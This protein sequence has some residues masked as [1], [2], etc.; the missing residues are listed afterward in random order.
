MREK[1]ATPS[2]ATN[3]EGSQTM[4]DKRQNINDNETTDKQSSV[5]MS[6]MLL[7]Q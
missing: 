5:R 7:E 4:N 6:S 2:Q 3:A 1:A